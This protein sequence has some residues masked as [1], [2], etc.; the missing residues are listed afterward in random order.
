MYS[1][2]FENKVIV[3]VIIVSLGRTLDYFFENDVLF[4]EFCELDQTTTS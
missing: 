4:Q 1:D 2:C 3:L